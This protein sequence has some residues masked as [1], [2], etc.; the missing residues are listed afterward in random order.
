M[1][2]VTDKKLE[3]GQ[4]LDWRKGPH[5]SPSLGSYGVSDEYLQYIGMLI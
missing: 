2:L 5:I 3:D 1:Q 4:T